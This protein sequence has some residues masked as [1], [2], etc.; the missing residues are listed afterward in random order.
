MIRRKTSIQRKRSAA[1]S[2]DRCPTCKLGTL[3]RVVGTTEVEVAP[4]CVY[5]VAASWSACDHCHQTRMSRE[6]RTASEVAAYARH[7]LVVLER[8]G[9]ACQRCGGTGG[10][11]HV[12]H[13]EGC[14]RARNPG[15]TK[16]ALEN[17]EA[18]CASCHGEEHGW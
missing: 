1:R 7:R 15:A 8:D 3:H 12:A 14:S 6:Q 10:V 2:S 9:W 18:C 13:K 4:G 11:L 17:L 5:L 16:H